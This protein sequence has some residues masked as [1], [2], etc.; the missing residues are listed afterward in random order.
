MTGGPHGAV[1]LQ[2]AYFEEVLAAMN[3]APAPKPPHPAPDGPSG[4]EGTMIGHVVYAA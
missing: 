4:K 1:A 2:E 3:A